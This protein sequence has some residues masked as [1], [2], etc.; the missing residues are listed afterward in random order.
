MAEYTADITARLVR[1]VLFDEWRGQMAAGHLTEAGLLAIRARL[2]S[3]N[4]FA[5]DP[6]RDLMLM[7]VAMAIA[8]GRGADPRKILDET[9]GVPDGQG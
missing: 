6:E 1:R 5:K 9:P 2:N 8:S 3:T 4:E 7:D